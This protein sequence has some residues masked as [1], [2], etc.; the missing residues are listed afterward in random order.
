MCEFCEE[1][2]Y[3]LNK[4][5]LSVLIEDD[6]LNIRVYGQSNFLDNFKINYCPMC[7]KKLG[8]NHH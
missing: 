6:F 2:H 8:D 5:R 3:L 7:G 1:E 4:N